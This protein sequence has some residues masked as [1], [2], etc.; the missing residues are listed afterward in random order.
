[1]EPVS[2]ILSGR[3]SEKRDEE[4]KSMKALLEE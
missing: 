3:N 4:I 1:M 2:N